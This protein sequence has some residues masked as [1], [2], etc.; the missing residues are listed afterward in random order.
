MADDSVVR[1][2]KDG[3]WFFVDNAILQRFGREL[4]PHGI[5]VYCALALHADR[6]TQTTWPSQQ[7][8]A[9]ETGMSRMQVFREIRKLE[10]L[11]LVRVAKRGR[12][13]CTYTL[14]RPP[15]ETGDADPSAARTGTTCN[16]ELQRDVTDSDINDPTCN[17][18]L[19]ADVTDSYRSPP[20]CNSELQVDV[21]G[22]YTNKTHINKKGREQDSENKRGTHKVRAGISRDQYWPI[23]AEYCRALE[24]RP[25]EVPETERGADLKVAIELVRA[26][27]T[28]EEV[29][30]C[31]RH[32]KQERFWQNK[33]LR[34][35]NVAAAIAQWR[36]RVNPR[37]PEPVPLPDEDEDEDPE[38]LY[39]VLAAELGIEGGDGCQQP[40]SD[41]TP[42]RSPPRHSPKPVGGSGHR[43]ESTSTPSYSLPSR[44]PVGSSSLPNAPPGSGTASAGR[45]GTGSRQ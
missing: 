14:A 30:A 16:S 12:R 18:Q 25:E 34:L 38:T 31:T 33:S 4:G 3:N 37:Q 40:R 28:A 43:P 22:G 5:A 29:G 24:I 35:R 32:L 26:G 20:K 23:F 10:R 42:L 7:T 36:R 45:V 27:Y 15:D 13:S 8:I 41:S 17:T 9:D 39:A 19:Q 44:K 2:T 1:D 21:T 11:G 6:I